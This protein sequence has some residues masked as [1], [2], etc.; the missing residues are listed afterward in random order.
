MNGPDDKLSRYLDGES[1]VSRAYREL[2]APEPPASLGDKVLAEARDAVAADRAIRRPRWMV[3]LSLAATLVVAVSIAFQTLPS[4]QPA[5]GPSDFEP[6]ARGAPVESIE[7]QGIVAPA[8]AATREP[9]PR[10]D[11]DIERAPLQVTPG[12]INQQEARQTISDA[13]DQIRRDVVKIA[14]PTLPAA[15]AATE[16]AGADDR[17][18]APRP[19]M[20]NAPDFESTDAERAATVEAAEDEA[21]RVVVTASRAQAPDE[22]LLNAPAESDGATMLEEVVVATPDAADAD[23]S[24]AAVAAKSRAEQQR[25]ALGMSVP[26]DE[27]AAQTAPASMQVRSER[28]A[29]TWLADIRALYDDGEVDEARAALVRFRERYPEFPLPKDFPLP[30]PAADESP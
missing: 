21:E 26:T 9:V 4:R 27:A 16:E 17:Q 3:P 18:F 8:P 30:D 1:A 22:V 19:S 24:K 2:D 25:N 29:Q 15:P 12:R 14:P 11:Y 6:G 28:A 13:S 7:E 5:M 10:P 23:K 20:A